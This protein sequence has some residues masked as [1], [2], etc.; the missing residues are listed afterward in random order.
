MRDLPKHP[1]AHAG[2]WEHIKFQSDM[3]AFLGDAAVVQGIETRRLMAQSDEVVSGVAANKEAF[4]R[5]ADQMTELATNQA[6]QFKQLEDA[7]AAAGVADPAVTAAMA[8]LGGTTAGLSSVADTLTT[9]NA[10][11]VADDPPATPSAGV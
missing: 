2:V 6:N 5:V 8:D 9:M 4:G 11:L 7:L 10:A 1:G 3:A